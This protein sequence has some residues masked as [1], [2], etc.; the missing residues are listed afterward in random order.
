[1]TKIPPV[2]HYIK[3]AAHFQEIAEGDRDSALEWLAE[4]HET[5]EGHRFTHIT[6]DTFIEIKFDHF[7]LMSASFNYDGQGTSRIVNGVRQAIAHASGSSRDVVH[8]REDTV[9][10]F[11]D[12]LLQAIDD[13]YTYRQA[14]REKAMV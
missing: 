14:L 12:E 10:A 11:Q 5:L 9:Q 3:T 7:V 2:S 1:M 8:G 6:G 13:F 4:E